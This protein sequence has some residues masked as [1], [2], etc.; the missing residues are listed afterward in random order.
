[1]EQILN[2]VKP[3]LVVVAIVLY[4][5]G[6]GLKNT[7]NSGRQVYPGNPRYARYRDLRYLRGGDLR[8]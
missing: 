4:F 5:V 3:E 6:V 8:P 7:G 2:Y 1:M